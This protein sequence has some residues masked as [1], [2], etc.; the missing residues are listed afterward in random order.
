MDCSLMLL[1]VH[2]SNIE[3]LV[4]DRPFRYPP[5]Q[6]AEPD[7]D[8]EVCPRF[9]QVTQVLANR[10]RRLIQPVPAQQQISHSR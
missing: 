1:H 4:R 10:Y 9:K 6:T 2:S 5:L 7:F 3:R 8:L